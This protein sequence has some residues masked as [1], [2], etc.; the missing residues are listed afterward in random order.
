VKGVFLVKGNSFVVAGILKYA[1][2]KLKRNVKSFFPQ[3]V[4]S[5]PFTSPLSADPV[6][7]NA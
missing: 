7:H 3:P 2:G 6:C 1:T 4:V 5:V